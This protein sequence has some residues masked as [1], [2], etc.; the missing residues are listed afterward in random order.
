MVVIPRLKHF[1]IIER[2]LV[3]VAAIISTWLVRPALSFAAFMFFFPS[4]RLSSRLIFWSFF[5]FFLQ[6]LAPR[7]AAERSASIRV[8]IPAGQTVLL[9]GLFADIN[10]ESAEALAG[11]AAK[12]RLIERL[13]GDKAQPVGGGTIR[14]ELIVLA[15]P[16]L[17]DRTA[18]Q[19]VRQR[20]R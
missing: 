9:G 12:P 1:L 15:T 10:L 4:F 7:P 5:F 3:L 17:D 2:S 6:I 16:K 18:V 14:R 19:P 8:V 13:F 11:G 20:R